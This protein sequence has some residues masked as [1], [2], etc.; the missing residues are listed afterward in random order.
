MYDQS[1]LK[2]DIALMKLSKPVKFNRYVRPICLPSEITA[3][4]NFMWG[5]EPGTLCTA[6]GW[7]ATVEHGSDRK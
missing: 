5:P 7:G 2:N 3:G 6:V 1:K 4:K